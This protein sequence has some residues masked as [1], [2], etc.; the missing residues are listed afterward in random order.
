MASAQAVGKPVADDVANEIIAAVPLRVVIDGV[1]L[2]AYPAID[3]AKTVR[4]LFQGSQLGA[5]QAGCQQIASRRAVL[6]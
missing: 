6:A 1:R 3:I 5:A 4:E 2:G